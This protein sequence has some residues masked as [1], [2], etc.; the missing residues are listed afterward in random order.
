MHPYLPHL[1]ADIEAAHRTEK[2]KQRD[3][4]LEEILDQVTRLENAHLFGYYCG[5]SAEIFPPA[6]QLLAKEMKMVN[7][8]FRKMMKSWNAACYLPRQLPPKMVYQLLIQTLERRYDPLMQG[9][10]TWG[11]CSRNAADCVLEKYCSC[12]A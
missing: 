5:L 4:L 12:L 6:E 9:S 7:S 2:P 1:L 3:Q 11:Y 8:A 10:V